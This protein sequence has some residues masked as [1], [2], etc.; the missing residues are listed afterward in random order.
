MTFTELE[1]WADSEFRKAELSP[2]PPRHE[3]KL[4]LMAATGL[5][6]A[7]LISDANGHCSAAAFA[8][9]AAYVQRRIRR[10]P[11]YRILGQRE[12]HSLHFELNEAT[13]EPR[14]DTEC[15][16][17]LT[18]EQISDRDAPLN[19]LDLGTGTGAVALS[20][21]QDLPNA[22]ITATDVAPKAL[23]MA[24]KNAEKNGMA[25]RFSP[26]QS[27]WFEQVFGHFDLIVSN[28]PYIASA[29]LAELEPEVTRFDPVLAL[30]GGEDG[31]D[32]YREILVNAR[33]YL[34]PSGYVILEIGHDQRLLVAE[35]AATN[36]WKVTQT[37]KALS[38]RDRAMCLR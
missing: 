29:G 8:I 17:E 4:L 6:K 15:L 3:A 11:V 9:F 12:F 25:D 32:A 18:L 27:N 30:D 16:I 37:A 26:L 33:E 5:D 24:V 28:P 31:L 34:A 20:L 38:G 35:L 22:H 1:I 36:G 10:E 13:L 7:G 2:P 23:Q 19:M 21:L 14:D